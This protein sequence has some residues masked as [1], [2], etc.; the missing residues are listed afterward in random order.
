MSE[1]A[2]GAGPVGGR[3]ED[4]DE[5]DRDA[6]G[7]GLVDGGERERAPWGGPH[8]R[9]ERRRRLG[10]GGRGVGHGVVGWWE[11]ETGNE[12]RRVSWLLCRFLS[13]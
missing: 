9:D 5:V 10:D 4:L 13:Q 3:G 8:R 1:E 7:G 6:D 2:P 11:G 12:R